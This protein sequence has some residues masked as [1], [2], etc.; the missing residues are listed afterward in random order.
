MR[1]HALLVL[2]VLAL[3]L[4]ACAVKAPSQGAADYPVLTVSAD[5]ANTLLFTQPDMNL[6]RFD[7]IHVAPVM[8]VIKGDEKSTAVATDEARRIGIH[9]ET[10][11]KQQLGRHFVLVEQPAAD[12]LGV[13]FRVTELEPTDAAQV[14]VTVP[15]FA[16]VN[17]RSPEG[18][19]LGSITISGE[20]Y[21]GLAAQPSVAFLATRS[22]RDIDATSAFG[23]WTVA[24][25][26]LDKAAERLARDLDE[27][28]RKLKENR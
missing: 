16:L 26:V 13:Y 18:P 10:A 4:S 22:H 9:A 23:R 20:I 17:M 27:E 28:R 25:G 3:G 24:E 21:E 14:A 19:F 2:P 11:L 5:E 15:P 12:A 8:V 1:T 7:K 6:G